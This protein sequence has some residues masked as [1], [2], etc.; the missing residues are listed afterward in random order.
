MDEAAEFML[1]KLGTEE[2]ES[3]SLE[4]LIELFVKKNF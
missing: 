2:D 4:D 1:D 3:A